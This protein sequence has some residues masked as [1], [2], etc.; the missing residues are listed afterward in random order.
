MFKNENN[1]SGL[2][3]AETI[4]GQSVKV[5]GNFHGDGNIVIEGEV[6]GSVKTNNHLLVG[7]KAVI[8]ADIQ[9]KDARIG[10]RVSGNI[11]VAG[12]LEVNASAR[13]KGDLSAGQ[14]SIE[15]GAIINGHCRMGKDEGTAAV[16]GK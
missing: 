16:A 12:Y 9:A 15:K 14:L 3:Q 7:D 4:I 8:T 10:G 1:D 2:K 11:T 13:I 6:E 5:K